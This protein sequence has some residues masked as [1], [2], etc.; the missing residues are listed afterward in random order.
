MIVFTLMYARWLAPA[1]EGR[2]LGQLS[3]LFLCMHFMA[4]SVFTVAAHVW[5]VRGGEPVKTDARDR[6]VRVGL[7]LGPLAV[8]ALGWY[9]SRPHPS[10]RT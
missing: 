1:V 7:V 9:A 8:I 2:P 10:S 6:L 5:E 3:T 4:Q